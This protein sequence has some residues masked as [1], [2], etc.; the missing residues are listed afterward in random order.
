VVK[1]NP[2]DYIEITS[3]THHPFNTWFVLEDKY[4][5]TGDKYYNVNIDDFKKITHEALDKGYTVGWDGDADDPD[6][7][8]YSALAYLPE[9]I[10]D[11]QQDRQQAFTTERTLLDHMMHIIA[12][13]KDT[14][15]NNWYYIKNS[16]G[17]TNSEGGYLFMQEDYFL[18]RTVAIIVNKNALPDLIRKHAASSHSNQ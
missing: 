17:A 2:D 18:Q 9:K 11:Q 16:W 12:M 1:L 7:H 15:G 14:T 10:T 5:W 8:F 6:F 4:N 3:Y 13:V